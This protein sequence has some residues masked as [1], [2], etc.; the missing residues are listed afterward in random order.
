[1]SE[2]ISLTP[3][4]LDHDLPVTQCG[5]KSLNLGSYVICSQLINHISCGVMLR[6]SEK[7]EVIFFLCAVHTRSKDTKAPGQQ[8]I[9][10]HLPLKLR[11]ML[12]IRFL[13]NKSKMSPGLMLAGQLQPQ[14][15]ISIT[16]AAEKKKRSKPVY[17]S[18]TI[19]P[20]TTKP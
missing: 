3:H 2:Y 16:K 13:E 17:T 5:V 18:V 4:R 9:S 1:M 7:A 20:K 8:T 6:L 14:N 10:V 11:S 12:R 15:T 19:C